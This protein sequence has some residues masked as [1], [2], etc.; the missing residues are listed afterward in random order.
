MNAFSLDY[1]DLAVLIKTKQDAADLVAILTELITSVY[2]L[3]ENIDDVFDRFFAYEEKKNFTTILHKNKIDLANPGALKEFF[4]FLKEY[5]ENLP[6]ATVYIAF[7]PHKET[8]ETLSE[9]FFVS[10]KRHVLLDLHVD[11]SIIGGAVVSFKGLY[12]DFSLRKSIQAQF[13]VER[14]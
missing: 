1:F 6:V 5:I 9:W 8:V 3:K 2:T 13:A 14:P 10:L 7:T 4:I 12:K 11:K